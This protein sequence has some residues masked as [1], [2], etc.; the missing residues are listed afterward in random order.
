MPLLDAQMFQLEHSALCSGWN[1][2]PLS[3]LP[4]RHHTNLGSN[5]RRLH[6]I[7]RM[8]RGRSLQ[9]AV[10][11]I[12]VLYAFSLQPRAESGRALLGIDRDSIFP[13]R[14]PAQHAIKLDS[15]LSRQF[16]RLAEFRVAY[17]G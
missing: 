15:G 4:L 10:H 9:L 1:T 8:P 3:R 16:Q 13:G 6:S 11:V 17:A 5:Q 2:K 7:D 14:A 12:D